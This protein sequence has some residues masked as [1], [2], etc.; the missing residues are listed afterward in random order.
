MSRG[1]RTDRRSR[2]KASLAFRARLPACTAILAALVL[3]PACAKPVPPPIV[4]ASGTVTLN[5]E[6]LPHVSIRFVPLFKG[7]G[8]EVIAEGVSDAK[9]N[10]TLVCM[11]TNGACVGPHRVLIEEGPLPKEAQGESGRAQMAMTRFLQSLDNRPIPAAYGN[12]AQ[13]PV[14]VEITADQAK[15]DLKLTR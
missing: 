13:S 10:F 15:Y 4:D 12:M 8:A 2:E 7:F 14:T 11:G 1:V 6:P 9:G 5:G 3:V